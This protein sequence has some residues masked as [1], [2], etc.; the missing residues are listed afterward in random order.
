MLYYDD[1]F[2]HTKTK[3]FTMC[4][5]GGEMITLGA[6]VPSPFHNCLNTEPIRRYSCSESVPPFLL[7]VHVCIQ[8]FLHG[9]GLNVVYARVV[10]P[11]NATVEETSPLLATVSINAVLTSYHTLKDLRAGETV[12]IV[13]LGINTLQ[14]DKFAVNFRLV[15][16]YILI[17]Q[18]MQYIKGAQ[19]VIA[20]DTRKDMLQ[21]ALKNNSDRTV[22]ILQSFYPNEVS[23]F[24]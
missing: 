6:S 7:S 23:S 5:E 19:A 20:V 16:L 2:K 18:S 17:F 15:V 13:G 4:H 14:I 12:L 10:V 21:K 8:Y 9:L 22:S 3:P 24:D 11:V 1:A